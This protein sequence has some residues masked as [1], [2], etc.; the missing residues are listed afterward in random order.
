M[1]PADS[2]YL[3]MPSSRPGR[4]EWGWV[5]RSADLSSIRTAAGSGSPPIARWELCSCSRCHHRLPLEPKPPAVGD[6]PGLMVCIV[7]DDA[8]VRAGL[9]SLLGSVGHRVAV[10]ETAPAF[11]SDG[12]R[13][14]V[15]CLVVDIRLPGISGLQ[16][17]AELSRAGSVIPIVFMTGTW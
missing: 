11:L 1:K 7:D 4:T 14:P 13:A 2:G 10:F 8:S 17:Q 12:L 15:G 9:A 6:P 5:C 3:L 16:L